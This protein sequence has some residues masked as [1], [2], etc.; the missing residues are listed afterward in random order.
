MER[1]S[2]ARDRYFMRNALNISLRGIGNTYPNPSVGAVVVKNNQI[3]SRGWTQPGGVPHAEVLALKKKNLSGATLYTTLEPCSH[4]GKSPPCVDQI[5]KSKIKRV[6]IGLK[7][8]NPKVNGKGISKL[9]KKKIK[10]SVG[11]LEN[12]IKKI[13]LSFF[14]KIKKKI[15]FVS[16]KI[17]VSRNGKMIN[18][19]K[20]WITSKDSRMYGNF[21]RAKF[22]A[23]ITGINTVMEDNPLLNCRIKGLE[24]T[25]PSRIIL[26]N[27][28]KV[29]LNSNVI[30]DSF[31]YKTII[32]Y[33]KDNKR[34]IKLLK[35]LG[36]KIYKIPVN[37][38][39]NLDLREV[40]IKAKKLG[41]TRIFLETGITLTNNF[42]KQNLVNELKIFISNKK[43]NNNGR[44]NI[45]K[46]FFNLLRNKKYE[47]EKVYLFNEK[48]ISYNIKDV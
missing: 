43:L 14:Y 29:P 36:I 34:K 15:P 46:Y 24:S 10:I 28:L 1:I 22:D 17:A 42:L 31:K 4:Y 37:E 21:L 23:V 40:L 44:G 3:I 35:N 33:N 20:K 48:L 38:V 8:P 7:D 12:E 18:K 30:K 19:N 13:H 5:I 9:R 47:V 26:D 11:I 16:S 25:S 45:R 41:F 32:F 2:S 39:G 27:N 6:V